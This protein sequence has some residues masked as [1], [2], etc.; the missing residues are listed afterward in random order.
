MDNFKNN[1][2]KKPRP[3][4]DGVKPPQGFQARGGSAYVRPS[5][6]NNRFPVR[7]G[8]DNFR[9]TD[10]FHAAKQPAMNVG[11]NPRRGPDGAIDLTLPPAAKK[12]RRKASRKRIAL[13]SFAGVAVIMVVMVG[14]LFGKGYLKLH[15][16]FKGGAEGAAALQ[17]NV[18][19][20]KLRGEG[21][22]RV[23]ILLLGRGGDGH[24]APDLTDTIL[25]ASLD[26]VQKKAALLSIPRD[27]WVQ[28]EGSGHTK[29]NAVYANAK[30]AAL[31]KKQSNADA[32]KAG[33]NALEK[34][35]QADIGIPIHYHV[36]VDFNAFQ[37]AINT[38]GGIDI[39]VAE[40]ETVYEVLYDEST[41]KHYTLDVKKGQQHFDGQR[42][43]FYARSRHTSARG[44][45]D[46]TERQRKI[47]L[48]LKDRVLSLGTFA[49]P[50]KISQLI[51]A[52]GNHVQANLTIQE[53][54]R[55]YDIGKGID[56][57]S[58]ASVGLA[59]SPNNYV[60]TDNINGVSIVRPRAGVDDF[61]EIQSYIRNSLK[62]GFIAN[63]NA[64]I[65]VY[66]GTETPGL[67]TRKAAELKSY[68]YNV[69]TIAD[70]PTKTYQKTILTDLRSGQKKYTKHYLEQRLGVTAVGS[71]PD[72]TINP[73]T[74]DFVIIL[75]SS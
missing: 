66:N 44:D 53:V 68:G 15:K 29:I 74:A 25:I 13:R 17:D 62:D 19:P 57:S 64:S 3:S 41:G 42:A 16:I 70:A 39:N 34:E 1:H 58:V 63:E 59:D 48:A 37:Q 65:A 31:A 8:L 67:A 26:P 21:D 2:A 7:S 61:S 27:L 54:M 56:S 14:F 72:T 52:F 40:S 51:D 75:G 43:L 46:R 69:I 18:D 6:A 24:E 11:R 33:L 50:A 55:L 36:M 23:N 38:V 22:G 45:F 10:G 47:M 28:P 4:F 49:N 60:I 73:G 71:L 35:I 20:S 30:Y 5:S 9:A 12:P 32:E